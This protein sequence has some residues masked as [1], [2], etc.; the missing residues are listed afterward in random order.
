MRQKKRV[1]EM[2]VEEGIITEVQLRNALQRQLIMGGKI[3]T[4]LIELEY[5]SED[6]LGNILSRIYKM[7]YV[8]TDFFSA[9][10]DDVIKSIPKE[11]AVRHRVI[12]IKKEQKNITIAM[13][14]PNNLTLI[15][16]ISFMTGCTVTPVVA[17]EIRIALELER[18]FD[19]PRVVRYIRIQRSNEDF[20][21]EPDLSVSQKINPVSKLEK[22][23]QIAPEGWL[24]GEDE[25]N[26]YTPATVAIPSL[27]E[28]LTFQEMVTLLSKTESRDDAIKAVIDYIGQNTENAIFFVT[29]VADAKV[30]YSKC[31]SLDTRK[32][33][34]LKISFGGPSLFL[35]VKKT[36][37]PYYGEISMFPFDNYFLDKIGRKRPFK[38]LLVPVMVKT[39]MAAVIYVDNNGKEITSE[40]IGE[41]SAIVEKLSLVFEI[42]ILKKKTKLTNIQQ[43]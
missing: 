3:G 27:P 25:Q 13:E 30:W 16:E 11:I 8:S 19:Q 24:G 6:Q 23:V 14:N 42:L 31:R 15:D 35:T 10:P 21:I 7:P 36:E 33:S 1:A 40:K 28:T 32:I 39:K 12:P 17:S 41:I 22:G 9:I 38:I 43:R 37:Q 26:Y 4:N 34:D 5:V 2:L 29:S 20:V 18:Y